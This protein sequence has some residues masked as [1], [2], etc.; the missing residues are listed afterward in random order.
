[1]DLTLGISHREGFYFR[2]TSNLEIELPAHIELGPLEIQG[3]TISAVPSADGLPIG[4]GASFKASLG[5]IQAV[6]EQIGLS[7]TSQ[8]SP[9]TT[10]TSA[11]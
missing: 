4:L 10:A 7:A 5:P 1:M 9:T 11:R 3:L 8:R 2:G 6:V